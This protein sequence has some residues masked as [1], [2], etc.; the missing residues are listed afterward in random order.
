[1][2]PSAMSIMFESSRL[3]IAVSS[4]TYSYVSLGA[5][6]DP[7]VLLV[8]GWLDNLY[9]FLVLA[10]VL[11]SSH[12]TILVDL[13]GHGWS[14]RRARRFYN[15]FDDALDL[16]QLMRILDIERYK[17]VGHSLGASIGS[18]MAALDDRVCGLHCID[19]F[20]PISTEAENL[21]ESLGTF[22]DAKSTVQK[23]FKSISHYARTKQLAS[24]SSVAKHEQI[25]L[26]HKFAACNDNSDAFA[27]EWDFAL[28]HQT[29]L[30]ATER[31]IQSLLERIECPT[32][33]YL[34]ARGF[35]DFHP[36]IKARSRV[37][38]T[39]SVETLERDHYPHLEPNLTEYFSNLIGNF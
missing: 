36:L 25:F 2:S 34:S 16:V 27:E 32:W 7:T 4:Q 20:G 30:G 22:L 17:V 28:M 23:K 5:P 39:V 9:S 37:L 19:A 26:G 13:P 15:L 6:S 3:E 38:S 1:M 14:P 8:H 10:P 21:C 33:I 29:P 18:V 24:K 11:A 12:H 35:N 31:Q